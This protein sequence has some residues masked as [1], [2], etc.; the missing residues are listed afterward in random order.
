MVLRPPIRHRAESK[1]ATKRE[2]HKKR[3]DEGGTI[4]HLKA[5]VAACNTDVFPLSAAFETFV[6]TK[7]RTLATTNV[8]KKIAISS[9]NQ[10]KISEKQEM[11]RVQRA[12]DLYLPCLVSHFPLALSDSFSVREEQSEC[13]PCWNHSAREFYRD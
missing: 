12:W 8:R 11:I 9:E 13:D 5:E 7:K 6:A 3:K 4:T 2:S 10:R 1:L